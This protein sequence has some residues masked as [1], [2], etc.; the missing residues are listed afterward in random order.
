MSKPNW[1]KKMFFIQSDEYWPLDDEFWF[2]Y[3][4]KPTKKGEKTIGY[5]AA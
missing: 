5:E 1:I 3:R 4:K 2:T